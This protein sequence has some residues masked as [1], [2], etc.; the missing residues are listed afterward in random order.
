MLFFQLL[1][2]SLSMIKITQKENSKYTILGYSHTTSNYV[3]CFDVECVCGKRKKLTLQQVKKSISCGCMSKYM[4]HKTHGM[5]KTAEYKTWMGIKERCYNNKHPSYLLYGGRGVFMCEEWKCNFEKF[6]M[7]IGTRPSKEHSIERVN[8]NE[9]YSKENCI[10]AT[11][12]QQCNNR[13]TNYYLTYKGIT[14]T[15]AQWADLIGVNVRTLASRCRANKS[16][17]E[18]LKEYNNE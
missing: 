2:V 7:D 8:V 4:K 12:K 1:F 14:L 5:S 16:I 10:W 9:G 3:K 17:E 18:I 13:R 6:L 11:R 15:R